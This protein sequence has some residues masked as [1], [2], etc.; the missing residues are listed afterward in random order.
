M[1]LVP[2]VRAPRLGR[3]LAVVTGVIAAGVG[4]LGIAAVSAD[5]DFPA[6]AVADYA[7]DH[8][9]A[10]SSGGQCITFAESIVNATY[11][12]NGMDHGFPEG[13]G[14]AGYYGIYAAAGAQL[15]GEA[16]PGGYASAL[17]GS[18]RG[19]IVQLSPLAPARSQTP[20]FDDGTGHQHTAILLGPYGGATRVVDSNWE[21]DQKVRIHPLA[22][23]IAQASRFGLELAVWQ[24]GIADGAPATA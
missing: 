1:E 19:D 11:R 23:V 14:A 24:F 22:D 15:V 5:G 21:E 12:E 17:A 4:A 20:W 10:G 3:L 6:S 18:Q 16:G 9:A 13:A 8:Y 2:G 7:V